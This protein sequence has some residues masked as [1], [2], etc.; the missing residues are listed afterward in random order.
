MKRT[1]PL[2]L[3]RG[4]GKPMAKEQYLHSFRLEE[5]LYGNQRTILGPI[6]FVVPSGI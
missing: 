2:T 1:Y 6:S 3:I 4:V 5:G